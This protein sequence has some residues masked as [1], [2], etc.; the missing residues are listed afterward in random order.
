MVLLIRIWI[1]TEFGCG[2]HARITSNGMLVCRRACRAHDSQPHKWTD[3]TATVFVGVGVVS[4]QRGLVWL[5]VL[6]LRAI[7]REW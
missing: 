2:K 4:K 6:C 5:S 3:A 7:R 1:R